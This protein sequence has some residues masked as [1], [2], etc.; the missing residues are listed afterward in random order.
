M[1]MRGK[2]IA[3]K[4]KNLGQ[5]V[6]TG[7]R[8]LAE[9]DTDAVTKPEQAAIQ[10]EL[11]SFLLLCNVLSRFVQNFACFTA[12]FNKILRTYQLKKI[13]LPA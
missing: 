13:Q 12:R 1:L 4:L 3:D 2:F 10:T 9:H 6:Q 11:C 7:R 5:I 8:G